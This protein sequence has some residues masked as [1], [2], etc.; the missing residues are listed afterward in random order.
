[1]NFQALKP[2]LDAE[3]NKQFSAR[4]LLSS[5]RLIDEAARATASYSDPRYLPF[6]YHLGK[7]LQP[8]SVLEFGFGLGLCSASFF[9]SC[10]TTEEFLGFQEYSESFYS[11]RL[12]KANLRDNFR[13]KTN[14]HV[15]YL[16]DDKFMEEFSPKTWDL[17][18]LNSETG[19]DKHMLYLDFVWPQVSH[20][21]V[22]V[23][24]FIVRHTPAREAFFAFCKGKNKEPVTF[25]TRYGIGMV[26]KWG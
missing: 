24:D 19:F 5:F 12:G 2:L 7:F 23:M 6:Y 13:K 15:G 26:Q 22:I 8:K 16:T 11:T 17:V 4:T 3:L 9:K 21:G 10:K 1:M 14:I 18:I 20:D 25:D